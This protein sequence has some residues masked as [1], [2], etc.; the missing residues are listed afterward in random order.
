MRFAGALIALAAVG[1]DAKVAAL[2]GGVPDA[3]ETTQFDLGC[4]SSG[5]QAN[6]AG[7]AQG[8]RAGHRRRHA[9][10]GFGWHYDAPKN[11]TK[12][13][14]CPASCDQVTMDRGGRID[15]VFGCATDGAPIL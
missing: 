1:C 13:E 14:L 12:V 15:V 8:D 7:L 10:T 9:K 11:P 4:A 2:D 6:R 5:A 3:F